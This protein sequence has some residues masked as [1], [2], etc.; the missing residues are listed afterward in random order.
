MRVKS[1]LSIMLATLAAF[2]LMGSFECGMDLSDAF[3][4]THVLSEEVPPCTPISGSHVDP[5]EPDFNWE[6]IEF[7][8]PSS[9]WIDLYDTPLTVREIFD[10]NSISSI[11]HIAIR[12]T[13]IPDT[14]RCLADIPYSVPS[15]IEPGYFRHSKVIECHVDVMAGAYLSGLGPPKLTVLVSFYHY[16]DSEFSE[17][18][19][20]EGLTI[21]QAVEVIRGAHVKKLEDSPGIY[22]REAV[23]FLGPPHSHST[24]AWEIFAIWDVQ[25]LED[26]TVIA[27]HPDRDEWRDARPTDYETHKASL[28]MS[29]SGLKTAVLAADVARRTQHG[30]TIAPATI[31]G[32]K[33]GVT[34]PRVEKDANALN[35]YLTSTGAYSDEDGPPS[36]P[37]PPCG[38]VVADQE[39]N[40]GLMA[41]CTVLLSAKDTLRGTGS[42]NWDLSTAMTSWDGVTIAGTPKRVTKLKLANKSLTGTIPGR[43]ADLG[44]LVELKLSGNALTGCIPLALKD[45]ATN[46]LSSLNLLYCEPPAPEGLAAGTIGEAS[47]PLTWT[48]VSNTSKYRV[49]YRE[50]NAGGWTVDD[51]TITTASHTVDELKCGREHQFRVSAYGSGTVYMAAWGDSSA[52]VAAT[53]GACTPPVFGATSY[54]FGVLANA[55][56][57]TAVGSVTATDAEGDDVTYTIAAGNDD[58]KFA[59]AKETGAITVA[60]DLSSDAGTTYTL[61]VEAGDESGGTATVTVTV[62]VT[63]TCDGGTAVTNPASNTGLVAD[64]ETLLGL[65]SALEGTGSLNWS[66][67]LAMSEWSGISV[68]DAP[69]RVIGV[70]LKNSGLGGVIPA[71]LGD[72]VKLQDLWLGGNQLTGEIPPELGNLT[73]LYTLYLDQN[74]L[75]GEIPPELGNMSALEDLFLYNNQ[76][77]GSIPP[78]VSGLEDLRQ[79]WIT[80]NQLTGVLPG[81]LAGLEELYTLRLRG[82]SFKGCAP[83]G[84]RDVATNDVSS[85][86]LEDCS[87][88]V[89]PAPTGLGASLA[90]SI[91]TLTWDAVTGRGSTRPGTPPTPQ[92]RRV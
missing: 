4:P 77:T 26:D 84:L 76:L 62:E 43:L 27:V 53:T 49:E 37:P 55:A 54:S 25:K 59:I 78:E 82:N 90:E 14:A 83:A 86:G 2:A 8:P 87:A 66:A 63:D 58:G 75:T 28:E 1:L 50:G 40:A 38:L 13:F 7:R 6:E 16:W 88:G 57:D 92:T 89:V 36:Q 20:A 46:D 19:K 35:H 32:K 61:T 10:G 81:E 71:A 34:L 85:L 22:G 18:A 44:G 21:A 74:R 39:G 80:N 73:S 45:V 33:S 91:F 52:P 42:L 41:D 67:S 5:C 11:S 51:D 23:L 9:E 72:L 60:G 30:L 68:S 31:E 65:K 24:E 79:L 17:I 56:V 3:D 12:G 69:R 47:V 64:C 15:Y 70:K 48:A 29:L